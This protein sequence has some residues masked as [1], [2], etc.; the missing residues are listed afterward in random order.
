MGKAIFPQKNGLTALVVTAECGLIS[1]EQLAV[2]N[3]LVQKYRVKALKM[4]TRQTLILLVAPEELA[5]LIREVS[6]VGFRIG[7]FTNTVRNVKGC[8][9]NADLCPRALGNALDL[10][11]EIQNRYYGQNTPHDFKIATAGCFR[12]CTDPLCAD[13]GIIC[14]GG[15]SFNVYIGGRGGGRKPVHGQLLVSRVNRDGVFTALEHV[16]AQ[17][18][19]LAQE[20]ERLGKTIQRVGLPPFV[21]PQTQPAADPAGVDADFLKMLG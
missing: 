3:R 18:R 11:I 5:G 10:G 17:Y 13:F 7:T 15:D 21:P 12:G 9:G 8:T 20:K 1:P 19:S 4:T 14:T 6:A 16:L 2:L